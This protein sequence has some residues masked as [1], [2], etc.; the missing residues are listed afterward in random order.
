MKTVRDLFVEAMAL[1]QQG[2]RPRQIADKLV[3]MGHD[4]GFAVIND[5]GSGGNG[6]PT[7]IELTFPNGELSISTAP[8]GI[9]VFKTC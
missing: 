3:D 6:Q 4:N 8:I 7:I 2:L 5:R 9:I 1:K